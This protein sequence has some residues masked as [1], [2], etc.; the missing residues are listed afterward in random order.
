MIFSRRLSGVVAHLFFLFFTVV[1]LLTVYN[2][3]QNSPM[4]YPLVLI[5][6]LGYSVIG[7]IGWQQ[8]QRREQ[9]QYVYGYFVLQTAFFAML[10]MIEAWHINWAPT[11]AI[12][13][14]PLLIQLSTLEKRARSRFFAVII[15]LTMLAS[16]PQPLNLWQSVPI[17]IASAVFNYGILRFGLLIAG[18]ERTLQANRQLVRYATEAEELATLRER[19]RLAREIHDNLGHYLTAINMQLEAAQAVLDTDPARTRDILIKAQSL[20]KEGLAEIRRSIQALRAGSIENRTLP[21]A[22]QQLIEEHQA[23]GG[24]VEY[25]VEGEKRPCLPAIEMTLYRLVQEGLTNIRKHAGAAHAQVK[26][27][28]DEHHLRLKIEDDGAGSSQTDG[29][30]GLLSSK[31]RVQ[32]VGGTLVIHT[33]PGH[34]FQLQVEIPA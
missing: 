34:G 31:E 13:S 25:H 10:M 1:P 11:T 16:T 26:L 17:W 21:E 4:G 3:V 23:A 19:N 7:T 27:Q 8:V 5:M 6:G 14:L 29:G 30:F 2:Q 15:L 24:L 12:L 28:Y 18:E 20:T 32:L 9:S 22:I 33:Q